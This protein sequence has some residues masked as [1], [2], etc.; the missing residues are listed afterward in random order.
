MKR[1]FVMVGCPASGKTH[2]A[3]ALMGKDIAY[4]S[5][6]E[7]RF[8]TIKDGEEY[9]GKEKEVFR[10]FKSYIQNTLDLGKSVI[11]DATHINKA[12]RRKLLNSLNLDGVEVIAVYCDTSFETCF[13]RN[14]KREGRTRVPDSAMYSMRNRMSAPTK[15]EGFKLIIKLSEEE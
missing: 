9:F 8:N 15:E 3:K 2:K 11:A 6:D 1:L 5:R 12:S 10:L 7:I 14:S 13:A 4:I